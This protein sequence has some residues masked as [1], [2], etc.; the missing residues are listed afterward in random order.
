[1][2]EPQMT[3]SQR[4]FQTAFAATGLDNTA[5]HETAP[6]AIAPD[7]SQI[8]FLLTLPEAS[9]VV[10]ALPPGGVSRAVVH[11]TVQEIWYFLAGEGEVWRRQERHGQ[12]EQEQVLQV[13]PGTCLSIPRGTHFQF[14]NTG[15]SALEFF[16]VTLPPWP[17]EEEAVRVEN[18]WPVD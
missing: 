18:H 6:D 15:A 12:G 7:G 9:T 4:K 10:C 1:M 11:K 2:A 3:E 8:R 13:I 14:R 17:G 16:I 5:L